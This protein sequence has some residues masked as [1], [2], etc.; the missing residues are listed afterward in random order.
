MEV[1]TWEQFGRDAGPAALK[2]FHGLWY[3]KKRLYEAAKSIL[4]PLYEK[5]SLGET[6]FKSWAKQRARQLFEN[7][8]RS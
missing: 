7:S 2:I 4:Q 5:H 3:E 8:L 6:N 1:T